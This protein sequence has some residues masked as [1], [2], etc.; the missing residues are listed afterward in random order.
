VQNK[1][2][3]YL[4][5]VGRAFIA[6]LVSFFVSATFLSVLYYAHY[7]YMTGFIVAAVNIANQMN[8][9]EGAR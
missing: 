3:I 4:N 6:S 2:M 5:Y 9:T 1:D 7:W 8:V